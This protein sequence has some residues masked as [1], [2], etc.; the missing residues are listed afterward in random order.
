MQNHLITT[1]KRHS[2][3]SLC[4]IT[5]EIENF[6]LTHP[7][8]LIDEQDVNASSVDITESAQPVTESYSS[9]QMKSN[10]TDEN[11]CELFIYD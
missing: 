8:I 9:N 7:P 6:P 4:E 11:N 3:S 10:I 5:H 1:E 2:K